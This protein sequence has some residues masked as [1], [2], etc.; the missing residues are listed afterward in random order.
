MTVV[1]FKGVYIA[2]ETAELDTLLFMWMVSW[3]T[4]NKL[5]ESV[6]VT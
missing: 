6:S 1:R 3:Y 2:E 4:E 5:S